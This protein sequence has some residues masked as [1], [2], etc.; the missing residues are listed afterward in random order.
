ML[1]THKVKRGTPFE[2]EWGY[3]ILVERV[4][5][6]G[7]VFKLEEVFYKGGERLELRNTSEK[8]SQSENTEHRNCIVCER[9]LKK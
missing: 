6:D 5:K 9:K 8:E 1:E 4:L 7:K 3:R 2:R